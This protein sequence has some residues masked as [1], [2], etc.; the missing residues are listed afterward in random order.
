M[1]VISQKKLRDYWDKHSTAKP[2]LLL[3]YKRIAKSTAHN[4]IELRQQFPGVD[5]VGNFTVF[6]IS[7][8]NH[9]LIAYIDYQ[10][11]IIFICTILTHAEYDREDWKNDHW[12]KKS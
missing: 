8:N 7:G 9:R 6:N 10:D 11:Q 1:R 5:A 12:F 3:W 4:L 2:G